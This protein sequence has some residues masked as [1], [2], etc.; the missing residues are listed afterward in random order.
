MLSLAYRPNPIGTLLNLRFKVRVLQ[1]LEALVIEHF[2]HSN[3]GV[4]LRELDDASFILEKTDVP[5]WPTMAVVILSPV[6]KHE[7]LREVIQNS[8]RI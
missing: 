5:R 2:L 8:V 6:P 4:K 3:K 1:R 7:K